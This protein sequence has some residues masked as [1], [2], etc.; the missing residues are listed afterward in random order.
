MG[1]MMRVVLS[2]LLIAGVVRGAEAPDGTTVDHNVLSVD[3]PDIV[4]IRYFG[5]PMQVK[6][7][8]LQFRGSDSDK[9]SLQYLKETLKPGSSVKI[10]LEPELNTDAPT[11]PLA[12]VF[13]GKVHINIEMVK[14][15]LALGDNRSKKYSGPMQTAQLEATNK[16]LGLWADTVAAAPVKPA[17]KPPEADTFITPPP[18]PLEPTVDLAPND[19]S[20]PVVADLSSKE[21]HF[22]Q[23]RYAKSI[24]PAARIEYKSP[25]EAERAGKDPSPFS[26]PERAKAQLKR[27]LQAPAIRLS[28]LKPPK[29]RTPKRRCSCRKHA[30]PLEPMANWPMRTGRKP[31]RSSM[32]ISIASCRCRTPIRT[33]TNCRS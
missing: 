7:A 27:S 24:R 25:S 18:K 30:R 4:R 11:P 5:V 1:R 14:R 8:N 21:Y 13:A 2:L 6:L 32:R 28:W 22:P 15:G 10:E 12:Q 16:K 17:P 26:F 29:S 9:Q 20:G 3:G 19:Y 23:S 31:R 33:T